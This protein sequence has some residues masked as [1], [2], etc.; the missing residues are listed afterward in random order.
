M[1]AQY[2]LYINQISGHSIFIR[3]MD[4]GLV[5]KSTSIKNSNEQKFYEWVNKKE[6]Y[7][8]FFPIYYGVI[9]L[10]KDIIHCPDSVIRWLRDMYQ[11]RFNYHHDEYLILEELTHSF[12][13]PSILDIKLGFN[14]QNQKNQQKYVNSTSSKIGFRI[15][16]M[17]LNDEIF[18]DKYWGRKLNKEEVVLNLRQFFDNKSIIDQALQIAESMIDYIKNYCQEV[19]CWDS[20]SLLIVH[21]HKRLIM[22]LIDFQNVT[23]EGTHNTDILESLNSF[24]QILFML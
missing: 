23:L 18:Y 6:N 16:G 24:K 7:G 13:S 19:T 9:K 17:K 1:N 10:N 12:E 22:K 14:T 21:D 8:N 5:A 3:V 4:S 15:N 11:Q 20:T 2:E